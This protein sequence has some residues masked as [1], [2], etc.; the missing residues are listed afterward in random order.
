MT[1]ALALAAANGSL[2]LSVVPWT[3]WHEV[4]PDWRLL[5]MRSTPKSMFMS[6]E[7]VGV[8]L[9]V[10]GPELAPDFVRIQHGADVVGCCSLVRKREYALG[11]PLNRIYLNTAGE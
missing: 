9:D 1:S 4:E 6:P 3:R 2:T 7:W 5:W 11:L 10:F 8:W